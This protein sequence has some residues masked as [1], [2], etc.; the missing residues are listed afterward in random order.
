MP[1]FGRRVFPAAAG[2]APSWLAM[3]VPTL[4]LCLALAAA[5][6]PAAQAT[7][8]AD[9]ARKVRA[10]LSLEAVPDPSLD[11]LDAETREEI[12]ASRAAAGT[13]LDTAATDEEAQLAAN[14]FGHLCLRYLHHELHAAAAVCLAQLRLLAP[15]DF[16]WTYYELLLPRRH[17][18]PGA[19]PA[20]RPRRPPAAPRRHG[21]VDSRRRPSTS[22]RAIWTWPKPPTRGRSRRARRARRRGSDSAG[23]AMDRG[24]TAEAI[25]AFDAVL[26]SQPEGSVVHHHL[27][28]ALRAS[29][30]TSR[31]RAELARNR[32]VPI[33]IVDPLRDRLQILRRQDRGPLRPRGAS[34][35]FRPE[36]R[37]DRPCTG[38]CWP[39]TTAMRRSTS[40]LARSLIETGDRSAAE[41]HLRRAIEVD[42]GHGP[43]HFNLALL[44]G[45]TGRT[46]E[47]ALH[48]ERAADIDPENLQWRLMRARARADAGNAAGARAELEEIVRLD[49]G[50]IE[51]HRLLAAMLLEGGE[52]A[53]AADH[54]EALAALTP[55]DLRVHFNLG[56][57]RFQSGR[58]AAARET[59]E[60]ALERFPGDLA[61]RH[62]LARLLATSPDAAVRDGARAVELARSVVDEQPAIDHLETL[63]MALAEA[64]RFEE[65][66]SWQR[67]ALD[68]ER[69]TAG[70]NSPQRL[71]RLRL[72]RAGQPL[73]APAAVARP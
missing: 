31:A 15:N 37:G 58:F 50:A 55:D 22:T 16:Q 52:P 39:R 12:A 14:A 20:R 18:Q 53:R 47:G 43:A 63:A 70:G 61:V 17:R 35:P 72:Y 21:D 9:D 56:L 62:L 49:P 4:L 2:A 28:M 68:R 1:A 19:R 57:T 46:A 30:D 5:A 38:N 7:Q 33:A 34:R 60:A 59:L 54:L 11:H 71:E 24:R 27:G 69:E 48:L 26:S 13:A 41:E 42:S 65:A 40:N 64:G 32:Q 10:L 51:A 45:R 25:A 23:V 36:R 6:A 67:R 29:G 44:L 8:P 73:R 66:V 3:H